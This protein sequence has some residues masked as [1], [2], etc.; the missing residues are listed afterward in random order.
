MQFT[1][2]DLNKTLWVTPA[3]MDKTR[4]WFVIDAEGK[5]LGKLATIIANHLTGKNKAHSCN[6]W[7]S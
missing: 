2:T 6:F 3:H 7:D 5:T 4:K 1:H